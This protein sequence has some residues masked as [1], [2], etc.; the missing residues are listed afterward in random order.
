[1]LVHLASSSQAPPVAAGGALV[2]F[3]NVHRQAV[4]ISCLTGRLESAGLEA[5]AEWRQQRDQARRALDLIATDR[6]AEWL[7]T[8]EWNDPNPLGRQDCDALV[9]L[10]RGSL[11]RD[12]HP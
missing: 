12:P 10:I 4:S 11:V 7:Q 2:V 9:S 1:M 6:A 5:F 8:H 3:E